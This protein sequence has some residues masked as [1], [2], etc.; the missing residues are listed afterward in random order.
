MFIYTRSNK[1]ESNES[2]H[3]TTQKLFLEKCFLLMDEIFSQKFCSL[4]N[5]VNIN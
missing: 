1:Y 2:T 3:W 4:R 5:I